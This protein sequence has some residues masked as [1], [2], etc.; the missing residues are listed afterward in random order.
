MNKKGILLRKWI[1]AILC[2]AVAAFAIPMITTVF[3]ADEEGPVVIVLDPGHGGSDV[4][5]VNYRD[6]LNEADA[7]LAIALACRD[8]LMKY[9]GVEVY[10]THTGL[11]K[12]TRMALGDRV[13]CV[14]TYD[15]DILISLHCNDSSNEEAHGSEVYV[16]HSH[17]KDSYNNDSTALAVEFLREFR[18]IG[19]RVRGVKTRLSNGSRVYYHDNGSVEIGDYYAVIGTTIKRY[20]VP[21][22]LVEHGFVTGDYGYLDSPEDLTALGIADAHAIAAYYGLPL[23]GEGSTV[24]YEPEAILVTD[25]DIASASDVNA[26][27]F[28][29]PDVPT[30]NDYEHMQ[31]VRVKYESL[32]VAGKTLVETD[33]LN[34]L[35]AF[36]PELDREMYPVRVEALGESE[37]SVDR[38]K[39]TV[40]GL[41]LASEGLAGT[42]VS[43]LLAMVYTH[44]DPDYA[45][46]PDADLSDVG[47]AVTDSTM[48]TVLDIGAQVG[49]GSRVCL[50][51]N[52]EIIDSLSVV[53]VCDLSGD[54]VADS[55]D[56]LLHIHRVNLLLLQKY[57]KFYAQRWNYTKTEISCQRRRVENW[58]QS[59]EGTVKKVN[60]GLTD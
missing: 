40:S 7:N 42:N 41:D 36:L 5:A 4:G 19:L 32:T 14:D 26:G 34:R 16:S 27:L 57:C 25:D 35:Y 44:I 33:Y 28:A 11:D 30:I 2:L 3:M 49:T 56:Q 13:A 58:V 18:E 48:E 21:G 38:I 46:Q 47:L 39:H 6:G 53:I 54:G 9:D 29:I 37:L 43:Q 45:S 31:S 10:M 12:S 52:G 50:F 59:K 17:Y 8:E 55:R 1:I 60:S 15:A 22:I 24:E 20:G 23:K 51:R